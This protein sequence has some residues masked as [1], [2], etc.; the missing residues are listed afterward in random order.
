[1][2]SKKQ[3]FQLHWQLNCALSYFWICRLA[4][5]LK[6]SLVKKMFWENFNKLSKQRWP[7]GMLRQCRLCNESS[8]FVFENTAVQQ[9]RVMPTYWCMLWFLVGDFLKL[10]FY[11]EAFSLYA[12]RQQT[13]SALL[14]CQIKGNKT[15][16]NT[17]YVS[18]VICCFTDKLA[19]WVVCCFFFV[20]EELFKHVI[21]NIEEAT[22]K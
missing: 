17:N 13:C 22:S 6:R 8:A 14:L 21:G 1:M 11:V 5:W 15:K 4:A 7:S 3:H 19:F 16:G 10:M 9:T 2:P 20:R 12:V 18:L